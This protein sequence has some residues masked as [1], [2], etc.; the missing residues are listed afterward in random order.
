MVNGECRMVKKKPPFCPARCD[1]AQLG[2]RTS[3]PR[4]GQEKTSTVLQEALLHGFPPAGRKHKGGLFNVNIYN[5]IHY[6]IPC[7]TNWII[8]KG[9]SV[10]YVLSGFHT[11]FC[12]FFIGN[13]CITKCVKCRIDNEI[14]RPEYKRP[15]FQGG[16]HESYTATAF[17]FPDFIMTCIDTM[18]P[19]Q[20]S[21]AAD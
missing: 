13:E 14:K 2:E 18:H 20:N 17:F 12:D 7:L 9:Y 15:F 11:G 6:D 3:Y 10:S 4:W 1:G 21:H 8:G 16:F 5:Y 19:S